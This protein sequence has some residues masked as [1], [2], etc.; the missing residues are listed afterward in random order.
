M[1]TEQSA[2]L[3][4]DATLD[5]QIADAQKAEP[6]EPT[7]SAPEKVEEAPKEDG[8]QKRINKVTADKYAEKRRADELQRKLDEALAKPVNA[9][10]GKMPTLEDHDFDDAA[11][12][13]ATIKYQVAEA[14]KSQAEAAQQTAAKAS[15]EQSQAAFNE[16]IAALNKSDFADVANAIPELPNGVADALVQSENGAELVYHLGTHLDMADKLATMSPQQAM[17]E[18]GRI[19]ANMSAQPNIKLSAAPD[20]IEP[21]SSGGSL[22]KDLGEMSMDEIYNM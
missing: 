4:E 9:D 2:A 22:S 10:Q 5:A 15:A 11:F 14:V 8:F 19:S 20:P 7:E 12:N 21:I 3:T 17:M 6:V 1:D 16:R 13:A 18:L